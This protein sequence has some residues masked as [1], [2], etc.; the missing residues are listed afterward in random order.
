MACHHQLTPQLPPTSPVTGPLQAEKAL[1]RQMTV[2]DRGPELRK[3]T[4][5]AMLTYDPSIPRPRGRK[6]KGRG[7]GGKGRGRGRPPVSVA[8]ISGDL[9]K[10]KSTFP[11]LT[12]TTCF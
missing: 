2:I 10:K 8:T 3:V 1:P 12:L 9:K 7:R 6:S 11:A 5:P 4:A